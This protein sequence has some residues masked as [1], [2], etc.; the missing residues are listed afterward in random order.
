MTLSDWLERN[1]MTA[2]AF[3]DEVGLDHSTIYRIMSGERMP[4]LEVAYVIQHATDGEVEPELFLRMTP[5]GYMEKWRRDARKSANP[6]RR[7]RALK[8]E[9]RLP[10]SA[11]RVGA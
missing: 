5:E 11:V 8:I 4:S 3:S 2:V 10:T 1:Q 7:A 9:A 6:E